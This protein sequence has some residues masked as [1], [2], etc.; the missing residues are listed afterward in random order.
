MVRAYVALGSSLGERRANLDAAAEKLSRVEGVEL[1]ARSSWYDT[2][3]VGGPPG[4]PRY[5]NGVVGIE[6]TLAPRALLEKLLQIEEELG[7]VRRERWHPRT[8][9]CDLVLYDD[10]VV[11]EPGLT[12]PHPRMRERRFVLE[13]L[14]EI[15]PEARDPVTGL[16]ARELLSRLDGRAD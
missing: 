10:S 11:D 16:T 6:T 2:A 12:I 4:Q 1:L 9:D 3:P 15:A 8:I 13:P 5:L 14:V 7:R